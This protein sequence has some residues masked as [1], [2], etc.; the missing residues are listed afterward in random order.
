M[1]RADMRPEGLG[2]EVNLESLDDVEL[3]VREMAWN[4]ARRD[5]LAAECE[6]AVGRVIAQ[7]QDKAAIDIDGQR[8]EL[9]K[10]FERLRAGV[11]EYANRSAAGLF[12]GKQSLNLPF[13]CIGYRTHQPIL[14]FAEGHDAKTV[15][16][17]VEKELGLSAKIVAWLGRLKVCDIPLQRLVK[18]KPEFSKTAVNEAMKLGKVTLTQLKKLGLVIGEARTEFFVEVAEYP[19]EVEQKSAA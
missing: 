9:V 17:K 3:A 11:L 4:K 13:G 12:Q 7:Y 15:L 14:Q 5:Q 1:A 10:R 6:A 19:L 8:V 18:L 16:A 2:L